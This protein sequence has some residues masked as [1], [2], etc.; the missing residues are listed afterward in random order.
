MKTWYWWGEENS[1]YYVRID[2]WSAEIH[3]SAHSPFHMI[4]PLNWEFV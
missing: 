2:A 4:L 1:R 3:N